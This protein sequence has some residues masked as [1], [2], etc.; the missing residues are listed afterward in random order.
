MKR[1]YSVAPGS[2]DPTC[3]GNLSRDINDGPILNL[4]S[5]LINAASIKTRGVDLEVD[6]SRPNF[7][8]A[9][10]ANYLAR[11]DVTNSSGAV[12]KFVD[13]P[14]FPK[15]RL[16]V[17][18][19][20]NITKQFDVFS[21][22]RYRSATKAFLESN[23]LSPDLNKLDSATYIDLR[24]NYRITDAV[25]AYVGINNLADVQPDVNPRDPATGTNTEP[26]AYDVIGRQY[27][28]GVRAVFK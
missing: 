20:Y 24:F 7:I 3:G 6:Y 8:V 27:F 4:R 9:A 1:C 22:I 17:N 23:N 10:Y 25:S 13:R 14:L 21:Q 28:V 18:G 16:S 5:P 19:T 15:W 11:Y 26:R 2:F 12:E